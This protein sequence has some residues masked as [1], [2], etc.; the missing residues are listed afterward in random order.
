MTKKVQRRRTGRVEK[1]SMLIYSIYWNNW[2]NI[3][4]ILLCDNK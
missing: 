2:N 4:V 3:N 1:K